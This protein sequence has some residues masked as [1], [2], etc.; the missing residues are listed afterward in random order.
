MSA[1][2]GPEPYLIR[3]ESRERPVPQWHW[4]HQRTALAV[5]R[6]LDAWLRSHPMKPGEVYSGAG[7]TFRPDPT[8]R[9]RVSLAFVPGRTLEDDDGWVDRLPAVVVEV[10]VAPE[11]MG[12]LWERL[13]EYKAAGV[14]AVW[15]MD[16]LNRL[17][18][19]HRPAAPTLA[20]NQTDTL[21]DPELPGFSAPV[22]DFFR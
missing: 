22:A 16:P 8:S 10:V 5:A 4:K 20:Y 12:L 13:E 14:P 18:T 3:G 7:F 21:T 15:V 1:E 17:M 11:R 9:F 6:H 19:V 2:A